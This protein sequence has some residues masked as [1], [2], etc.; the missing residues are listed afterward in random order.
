MLG[1]L[2][3]LSI[4][5]PRTV[6]LLAL[7]VLLVAAPVAGMSTKTLIARV[8]DFQDPGSRSTE[9]R[10]VIEREA[11]AEP[12]PGVLVNVDAPPLSAEATAVTR[13]LAGDPD[14]AYY[15]TYAETRNANLVSRD[16]RSTIIPVGLHT[17]TNSDTVVS[18]LQKMF[19]SDHRVALGGSDVALS[20][21][22]EQ[23]SQDLSFAEL[24]VFPLL[25]L[26]TLAIFRGIAVV[27]PLAIGGLSVVVVSALVV[28]INAV[29]PL[30]IFVLNLVLGLGLGLAV[31]YSLFVVSRFREEIARGADVPTAVMATMTTAGRTVLFSA[32]VVAV[33]GLSLMVFPMR[34]LWSLGVGGVLV[35]ATAAIVSLTLLPAALMLLGGRIGSHVPGQAGNG[36]WYRLGKIVARRP[37]VV[38][39]LTAAALL[40]VASP[41]LRAH[42]TGVSASVLPTSKSA[43][44]VNDRVNTEFPRLHAG[45]MVFA[46]WAPSGA[47]TQVE[48]YAHRVE[49]IHG[50][51]SIPWISYA[52]HGVW[53]LYADTKGEQVGPAAQ[54]TL[55]A[56]RRLPTPFHHEAIG[57]E[58][59]E[60]HDL[61]T[62]IGARLPLALG[63]LFAL[64][65]VILW[66]MT[67]SILLPIKAFVM[68]CLT[69]G[70]AAGVLVFVFQDGRFTGF[71]SYSRQAGIQSGDFLVL[72]ALMFAL[73]TDY[74]VFLLARI[75]EGRN[76]GLENDEA[77][78]VGLQRAGYIVTAAALLL[79]TAIGAFATSHLIFLKEIGVGAVAGLLV[80]AFVIR[81]LLVPSLMMLLGDLNWWQPAVLCRLHGLVKRDRRRDTLQ[82]DVVPT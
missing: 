41:S 47:G 12:S 24:L 77:V 75:K 26:L 51:T 11:G 82:P 9:A 19:A 40:L 66:V 81:A 74:G 42:W 68:N 25:A 13:R 8:S 72:V 67:E 56:V 6:G 34:F 44:V 61:E 2:A 59:A 17:K 14:V 1:K 29:D 76:A 78:A 52:N 50:I 64:T 16:G 53:W 57:G 31:D 4:S 45:P 36:R 69:V 37:G 38:A 46:V 73:S 30:S 7:V 10:T 28:A 33:A 60:F 20:Q 21:V 80:D 63:L 18:R 35:A 70:V 54:R 15:L 65:M 3:R 27:L 58:A 49:R 48:A 32:T 22:D 39:L 79:A 5:R 62:A 43:R 23:S 71:L 55:E